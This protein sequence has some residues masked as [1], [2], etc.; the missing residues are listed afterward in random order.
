MYFSHFNSG[1]GPDGFR[2][3]RTGERS[4]RTNPSDKWTGFIK[5][6]R[7]VTTIGKYSV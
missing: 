7:G 2:P 4:F 1:T 3:V 5:G 6:S